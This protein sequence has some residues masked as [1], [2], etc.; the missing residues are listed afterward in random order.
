MTNDFADLIDPYVFR[1]AV[2]EFWATRERQALS[3]RR[4]GAQDRGSRAAV[5]GGQQM[6]GFCK[7]IVE[8]LMKAGVPAEWI[9]TA[10][11][12]TYIPGYFRPTKEWD[13]VVIAKKQLLAAIELK[14]QVGPSFGNNFNNRAEEAL[15]SALDLWTAYR[16][17]A[18]QTTPRPFLGFL[19]LLEDAPE[20][21]A[22]VGVR[23]PHFPVFPE[24]REASYVKRYELLCRKMV[25]ERHYSAACFLTAARER[26]NHR[27]N[28]SEPA[29]DLSARAFLSE[30]LRHV[31]PR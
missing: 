23:E 12:L 17:H 10:R 8:L 20:A 5:T 22:P 2:R 29:A 25:L 21:R 28:Y 11:G 14:A 13:L 31:A 27:V 7:T 24:F 3:Q 9:H 1:S 30:L 19:F 18:F 15:G 6:N 16:E 26:A 4:R